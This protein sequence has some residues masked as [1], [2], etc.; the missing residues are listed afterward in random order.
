MSKIM[1]KAILILLAIGVAQIPTL[2]HDKLD[3]FVANEHIDWTDATDNFKTSGTFHLTTAKTPA[4]AFDTGTTGQICWDSSY[5]YI[6]TETDTWERASIASWGV[7]PEYLLLETGDT[8]LLETGDKL[9]L[10]SSS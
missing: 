3:G 2:H 6:C 5:I 8:L 4:S 10:E 7:A 1:R 9:K